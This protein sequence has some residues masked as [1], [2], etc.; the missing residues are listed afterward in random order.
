M[1]IICAY[2]YNNS[3]FLDYFLNYEMLR[4]A[5]MLRFTIGSQT[6]PITSSGLDLGV[7]KGGSGHK[8]IKMT[9]H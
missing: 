6:I 5:N 1:K 7:C 9:F 4:E 8:H 3:I 2:I